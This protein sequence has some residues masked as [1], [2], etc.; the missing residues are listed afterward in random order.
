[1]NSLTR[2]YVC[3][4]LLMLTNSGAVCSRDPKCGRLHTSIDRAAI[5]LEW[6]RKRDLDKALSFP[7]AKQV[8]RDK[9]LEPVFELPG[10]D[11]KW[12]RT[13]NVCEAACGVVRRFL[14]SLPQSSVLGRL[15]IKGVEWVCVFT[16]DDYKPVEDVPYDL[17]A[18][19]EE[20]HK[21]Q[22]TRDSFV[23][24]S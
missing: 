23:D 19:V 10:R 22:Q 6:D 1:M 24:L 11:G 4:S 2:C 16:S 20:I 13:M 9:N 12:H 8:G 18:R 7:L 14:A 3:N 5:Q 17:F 21:E 15:P